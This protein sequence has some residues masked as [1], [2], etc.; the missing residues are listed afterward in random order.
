MTETILVL[1]NVIFPVGS[2]REITQSLEPIDN[3][4]IRRTV[5]GDAVD[6]TRDENRKF[7]STISTTDLEGPGFDHLFKGQILTGVECIALLRQT[8]D[9]ASTT[10]TLIR[11]EVTGSVRGL[12]VDCDFIDPISVVAGLATFA[13]PTIMVEFRP[14]LNFMIEGKSRSRAEMA[15][16][17][18]WSITLVEV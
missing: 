12:E 18:S 16:T 10:V 8:V 3:G 4:L 6:L 2:D 11:D 17:E 14:V 7:Q 5:N 15:A 1:G 9:P 13:D